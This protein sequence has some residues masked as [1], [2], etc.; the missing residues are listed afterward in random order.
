MTRLDTSLGSPAARTGEIRTV[1]AGREEDGAGRYRS[2]SVASALVALVVWQL[3]VVTGLLDRRF[4]APPTEIVATV[5]ALAASGELWTDVAASLRRVFAGFALG[6]GPGI[7]L[8]L[9]MGWFRGVRAAADPLVNAT[10]PIPKIALL[11]LFLVIFGIGEASKIVTVAVAGFFLVLIATADGVSRIDPVLVQAA[12]NYGARGWKLFSR[13]VV[14]AALPAIFTGLRLSLGISLV[15]IVAAEFV[16]AN[17][18]IGHLIWL[19]W[20]TLSVAELYAGIL[21]IAVLGVVVMGALDRIGRA[22]MPWASDI[23]ERTR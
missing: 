12:E 11:P 19:S 23:R 16:A 3:V 20:Q 5:W 10:F 22:L 7:G 13:V 17:E 8:G 18:G 14:P 2:V 9:L 21:V 4:F 15:I 1:P 6:A